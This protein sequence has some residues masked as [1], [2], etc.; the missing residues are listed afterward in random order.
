MPP[1]QAHFC[2]GIEQCIRDT[3]G[4]ELSGQ[5]VLVALSGGVDSTALLLAALA[6]APRLGITLC[7]AHLN[8]GLRPEAAAEAAAVSTLCADLGVR[9]IVEKARVAEK[10]RTQG[11]GLEEAGRK[12]RYAFLENVRTGQQA[13]WILLGHHLNDLAEDVLMRLIRGTGWPGLGGMEALDSQRRLLRPL[14]LIPKKQLRV[15]VSALEFSWQEDQSNSDPQFLRNR[16]RQQILPLFLQENPN[17]LQNVADLWL[18]ARLDQEYFQKAVESLE[19]KDTTPLVQGSGFLSRSL[20]ER[21]PQAL[22]LRLYKHELDALG[23][24]QALHT[25]LRQL[26]AAWQAR[27]TGKC[28]QFPGDK[29][30]RVEREGLRFNYS[31]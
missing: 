18:L 19:K 22:R 7:A 28:F 2:L 25:G 30:A 9:C 12:L 17:F 4:L 10:A 16:V 6:L 15:F 29:I 26:D 1:R 20:L 27:R 24:G 5:R 11:V 13:D 3:L 23:P 14:L 31:R 8:H 21:A